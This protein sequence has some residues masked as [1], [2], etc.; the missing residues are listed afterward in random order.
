MRRHDIVNPYE[1]LKELTHSKGISC[2][3]LREFVSTLT[4]PEDARKLLLGMTPASYIG[5]VE[6]LTRRIAR[7]L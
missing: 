2:E 5:K 1:Q 6:E 7:L 3:T 4:I